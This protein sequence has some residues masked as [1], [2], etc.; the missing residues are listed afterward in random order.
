MNTFSSDHLTLGVC[1]YPEHVPA[2]DWLKHSE[3]QKQIGLAIVRLAEFSWT[4]LEPVEGKFDWQWLDEAISI[5]ADQGLKIVLCTPTATPPAWLIQKYPEILPVDEQGRIKKFGSRRH[6]DHASPIYRKECVRIVTAMAQRYGQHPAVI[7][8]QTDNELG[9]EGTGCSYGGA[10]AAEFPA[11]LRTKYG[12]LDNLNEAWGT[13]FWSQ[14]YNE[15]DQ[16]EPPNLTAVRQANPSQVLDFKRFCSAMIEQFQILQIDVLRAL[17]PGRFITHNFVTFS[18]ESDLYRLCEKLDFVAWD[19]YP[20]GMLEFFATWESEEVKSSYARTG[21]PDLVSLHHD[22]YRGLKGGTGFWVMEQ[23]CGH[24]NWA[25]YNPLPADGAVKLWSAQAWSHGAD[26]LM[27]FRWRACHM[28]QEIMH[29]GLLH[30]NGKPDRGFHEVAELDPS[31]F[32]LAPVETKVAV[33]HDYD[34]LWAYDQQPHNKDLSYWLQFTM[35]YSALRKLGVDVDII[36]PRQ[37]ADKQYK[38]VVAPALTLMTDEIA[39][40]LNKYHKGLFVFGPRTAFRNESGRVAE[41]GQFEKIEA[42]VGCQLTNFDSL[43]PTLKQTIKEHNGSSTIEASLWCE[44]YAPTTGAPIWCYQG[45]PLDGQAAVNQNGL[46]TVVGALSL[47]LI[48]KV[49]V[50]NLQK[51]ELDYMHLPDGVRVSQRGTRKLVCNFNQSDV[52]WNGVTLPAVSYQWLTN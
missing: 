19:S 29:S 46:V 36:H 33:L 41:Q 21:H 52:C 31:N 28:A 8:W 20:V 39:E 9:H 37:L 2:E 12:S 5:Y 44:G 32:P 6:Y 35:F 4:K 13:S 47:E 49:L 51:A 48:E 1:D 50:H 26:V 23:Q 16:I 38:L 24:A 18:A 27:Y 42:L 22:L 14:T 3:Q 11:W 30:Q 25:Q 34:S 17:S 15:W 45:G 10:S 7:G 43:R 40:A